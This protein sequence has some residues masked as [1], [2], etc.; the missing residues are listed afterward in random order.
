MERV[1]IPGKGSVNT[2]TKLYIAPAMKQVSEHSFSSQLPAAGTD[3][4]PHL[5]IE[6]NSEGSESFV[7][8][9]Y[10]T[11]RST[12]TGNNLWPE[13]PERAHGAGTS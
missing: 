7:P 5:A 4:R 12:G 6:V 2:K 11:N 10:K 8:L 13:T 3:S 9:C 1:E